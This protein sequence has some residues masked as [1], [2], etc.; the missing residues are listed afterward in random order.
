MKGTPK[1]LMPYL[2][3]LDDEKVYEI[4]ENLKIEMEKFNIKKWETPNGV[5]IT[6]VEDMED[7]IETI[8]EVNEDLFRAEN[9]ELVQAYEL[10]QAEYLEEKEIIK[11]GRKGYIK[12]TLPS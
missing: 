9:F 7:K 1:Q 3:N 10:K 8:K 5:K 6:L 2:V 12:I 4:K 11:K